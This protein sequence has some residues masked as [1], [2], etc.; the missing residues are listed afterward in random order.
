MAVTVEREL[1]HVAS[2]KMDHRPAAYGLLALMM[3][4]ISSHICTQ[5]HWS[6]P[7][8]DSGSRAQWNI[9][10]SDSDGGGPAG[11]CSAM[12]K[13][14]KPCRLKMPQTAR[15]NGRI[16]CMYDFTRHRREAVSEAY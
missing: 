15:C 10:I 1:L 3:K 13:V 2:S 6:L 5:R 12:L 4:H 14:L 8:T 16:W 9:Y 11:L 7:D